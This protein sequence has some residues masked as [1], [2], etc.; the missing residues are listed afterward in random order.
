[1]TEPK[2]L[3][4]GPGAIGGSVAAWVAENYP[5]TFVIGHG[6]TPAALRANGLTTYQFD[7]P[8]ATRRTVRP[9]IVD[10]PGE[11]A[12]AAIVVLAVKNYSL[13][14][15]AQQVKDELGDRPIVVSIAN[16]VDNQRI[17]PKLF[18]KVIYGI[19][20]Y[21]ARREAPGVIGYQHKLPLLIGTLD[22]ASGAE[23]RLVQSVLGRGCPT[24]IVERMQDAIH[25]KIVVNL[26]NAL[27]AL[28]GRGARPLSNPAIFQRLLTQTLW[29]GVRTIRAARHREYRLPGMP[30]FALL[31][32]TATLPG[33]LI[34]PL[35]RR[36][37]RAMRMS[38]MTQDVMQH[39]AQA[40]E[41]ESITGYIVDLAAQHG[42]PVPYNRAILK[43][44]RERFRPGFTPITCEEV[45]AAVEREQTARS[46]D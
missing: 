38:S 13:D 15:V 21:N 31:Q 7:E 29:E 46:P 39:G 1:M 23:M 24:E 18:S 43:L 30:S 40:T 4:I 20:S 37:L 11:V 2:I 41:L 10:R 36:R 22:N 16:G 27:D 12:D 26:T 35:F 9:A 34:R 14:A 19:A 32:L 25:T 28:V 3:F 17:L 5:A 44:G 42:V 8:E 45:L 33:W 6:A